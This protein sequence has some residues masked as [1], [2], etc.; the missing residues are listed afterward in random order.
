LPDLLTALYLF[1]CS[2]TEG[3]GIKLIGKKNNDKIV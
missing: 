1:I 3:K 2:S